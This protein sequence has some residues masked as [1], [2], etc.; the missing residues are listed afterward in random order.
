MVSQNS[1][2]Q[3][4]AGLVYN[5][6]N[7]TYAGIDS[8]TAGQV[9]IASSTGN[10]AFATITGS[11]GI[12]LTPGD[13][14]LVISTSN[15]PNSALQNSSVTVNGSNGVSVSGSP[16]SLGGTLSLSTANIP[17]TSLQNSSITVVSSNSNLTVS[18]SPVSLGGTVTLTNPY[19]YFGT[20]FQ[21]KLSGDLTNVSGN[22][23][24]YLVKF[25]SVISDPSNL[26]DP[27]TGLFTVPSTGMYLFSYQLTLKNMGTANE[28]IMYI[29]NNDI[30]QTLDLSV[31]PNTTGGIIVQSLSGLLYLQAS[32][33][34]GAYV[35]V[36]GVGADTVD[37]DSVLPRFAAWR[38]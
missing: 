9:I 1:I 16:V 3:S 23:T 18:G 11:N 34:V 13:N 27:A 2:Y 17:N 4:Q 28:L 14:S 19:P 26:Y 5:Q 10:P 22:G 12:A 24:T 35:I 20:G 21:Y 29:Q 6:G 32:Q 38:L 37:I 30:T 33:T 36:D 31:N 15:I 8:A 7:G 25:D